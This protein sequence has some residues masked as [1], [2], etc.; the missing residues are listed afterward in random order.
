MVLF[1]LQQEVH[2][3][4]I[5]EVLKLFPLEFILKVLIQMV[6][7][8]KFLDLGVTILGKLDKL[9]RQVLLLRRR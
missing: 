6:T 1:P 2:L 7:M 8:E 5:S 3:Q 9:R 4:L